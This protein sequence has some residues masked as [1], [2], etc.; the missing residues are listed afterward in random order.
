MPRTPL[1]CLIVLGLCFSWVPMLGAQTTTT[2][3][4]YPETNAGLHQLMQDILNAADAKDVRTLLTLTQSLTLPKPREWFERVFGAEV[5]ARLADE[6]EREL[7]GAAEGFARLFLQIREPK[8]MTIEVVRVEAADDVNAKP[9]QVLALSDMKNPVPLYTV[10][11]RQP[12]RPGSITIWSIV[13][14]DGA[15]RTAGKM[16]AIR[17][18]TTRSDD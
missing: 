6:H 15:F 7:K 2:A 18:S 9:F 16:A 11:L 17:G 13:Y 8:K 5:G 4:S 3:P 10:I 1:F 14:V 12:G